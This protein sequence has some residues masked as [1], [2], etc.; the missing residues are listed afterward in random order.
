MA[1]ILNKTTDSWQ[2]SFDAGEQTEALHTLEDGGLIFFPQLRFALL[3]TE[4]RFLD[5]GALQA[6]TKNISYEENRQSLKGSTLAA[7]DAQDLRG[8]LARFA[9]HARALVRALLPRYEGA[10]EAARASFRPVE[11]AGRAA[12]WRQ[13]DR[14]LHVDAFPS[15][16][17]QGRRLLRVFSNVHPGGVDRVWKLGEPFAGVACRYLPSLP[18]H[19][20]AAAALLHLVGAT[21][22]RRT[23]YDH[24]M[25]QLHDRMKA[26]DDYQA[27]APATV[28]RFPPGSTWIVCTDG[29][30]HAALSGQFM[31]E[32]TFLLPVEAM[33]DPSRAPLRVLERAL[34]RALA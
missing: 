34:G 23:E 28:L 22:S 30:P 3:D 8:M 31:M 26:D 33:L 17:N 11:A 2:A 14:R 21:R 29:V 5:A 24:I 1:S 10:L 15:R 16:P 27:N 25:L 32:Q 13:D 9:G 19:R 18:R 6:G 7:G 20:P 12:S 4:R